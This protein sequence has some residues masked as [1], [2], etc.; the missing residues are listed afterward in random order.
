MSQLHWHTRQCT[1]DALLGALSFFF[2]SNWLA[3]RRPLCCAVLCGL[4]LS[5]MRLLVPWASWALIGGAGG[6]ASLAGVGNPSDTACVPPLPAQ[7][8]R[9]A[10]KQAANPFAA[11]RACMHH[12]LAHFVMNDC[13]RLNARRLP[14]TAWRCGARARV[15]PFGWSSPV[16]RARGVRGGTALGMRCTRARLCGGGV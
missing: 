13:G 15:L 3:A 4:V 14:V 6:G 9:V 5:R 12:C 11:L 7:A 16:S 10:G 2:T 8:R 1:R